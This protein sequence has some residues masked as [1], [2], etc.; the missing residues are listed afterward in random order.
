MSYESLEDIPMYP[1][2]DKGFEIKCLDCGS[3]NCTIYEDYD[4]DYNDDLVPI[5]YRIRCLDCNQVE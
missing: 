3:T 4:Y 5:G 1:D 2:Q